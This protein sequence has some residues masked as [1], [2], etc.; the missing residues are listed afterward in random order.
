MGLTDS[1]W[2]QERGLSHCSNRSST[3]NLARS[4][5]TSGDNREHAK[6]SNDSGRE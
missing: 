6:S 5:R 3:A 4:N 1:S 2:L